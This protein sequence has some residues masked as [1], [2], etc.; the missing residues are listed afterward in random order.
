MAQFPTAV[1]VARIQAPNYRSDNR[2]EL[3]TG[4][5]S[6]VTTRDVEEPKEVE[7]LAQMPGVLA[8][9]PIN[10]LLMNSPELHSDIE[11]R[12]AA[13]KLHRRPA[14]HLHARYHVQRGRQGGPLERGDAGLVAEP[15]GER[16]LHGVGGADGHRATAMSTACPQQTARQGQLASAWTSGAA[17]DDARKRAETMAFKQLVGDVSGRGPACIGRTAATSHRPP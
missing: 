2:H 17:V 1:A 10:R 12:Q 14:A 13:A 9:A 7:R 3:G 11:L 8:I 4:A 16:H 6:I 15:V 5:Y